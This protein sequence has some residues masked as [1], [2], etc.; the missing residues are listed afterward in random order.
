MEQLVHLGGNNA[1]GKVDVSLVDQQVERLLAK[2][3]QH[4]PTSGHG[5]AIGQFGP[6]LL[7]RLEFGDLV[8]P[9]IVEIGQAPWL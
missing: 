6:Q 8:D 7:D 4:R 1:F 2:L 3:A 9:V 5:Q